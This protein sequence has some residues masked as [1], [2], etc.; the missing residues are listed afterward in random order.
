MAWLPLERRFP[1]GPNVLPPGLDEYTSHRPAPALNAVAPTL[2]VKL[3]PAST[4]ASPVPLLAD[5]VPFSVM[6]PVATSAI[7]LTAARP[8]AL[9]VR[10]PTLFSTRLLNDVPSVPLVD[11]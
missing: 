8:E 4:T 9:T 3:V 7:E 10:L 6:P 11:V 2:F 5:T 1:A